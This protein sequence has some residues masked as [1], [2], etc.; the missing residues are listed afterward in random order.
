MDQIS[1]LYS[2]VIRFSLFVFLFFLLLAT[3]CNLGEYFENRG[4]IERTREMYLRALK[5]EP[6]KAR[7]ALVRLEGQKK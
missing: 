1:S 5:Q 2:Q 6:E 4:E 3:Y 7:A